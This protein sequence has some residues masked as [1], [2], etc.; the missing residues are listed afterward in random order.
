MDALK[1]AMSR[2]RNA[3]RDSCFRSA[4][5]TFKVWLYVAWSWAT[6]NLHRHVRSKSTPE[7]RITAALA[8]CEDTGDFKDISHWFFPGDW[9]EDVDTFL[10]WKRVRIDVRYV[11][12]SQ[13]GKVTKYRMVLRNGDACVFPPRLET[14]PRG[15]RGVLAA[16]LEPL[17]ADANP[18]DVT[19][20][21]IKYAGPAR[22]FHAGQG[23]SVRPLDCFPCD[24]HDALA[25]RF[26]ALVIIDAASFREHVFPLDANPPIC[27]D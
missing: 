23:L 20:R 17:V 5:Q 9:Q 8:F 25:D 18:V 19:S 7:W 24:D 27:L 4:W 1:N 6:G 3:W 11:H 15:P 10:G 26:K 14:T 12:T 16:R 13:F 22:D 21:V 2:A